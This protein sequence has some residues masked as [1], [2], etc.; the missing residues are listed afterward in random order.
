MWYC[1]GQTNCPYH[2]LK[3]GKDKAVVENANA[4]ANRHIWWCLG[5]CCTAIYCYCCCLFGQ[6]HFWFLS[7]YIYI[8]LILLE[9]YFTRNSKIFILCNTPNPLLFW[10]LLMLVFC[11]NYVFFFYHI[12]AK[13]LAHAVKK[14]WSASAY[15]LI[16]WCLMD[17]T[18]NIL[19]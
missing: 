11:G 16:L 5:H 10:L 13:V 9:S 6:E 19:R 1:K 18:T 8:D 2:H 17:S 4:N 14:P 7:L 12:L 15:K 3:L